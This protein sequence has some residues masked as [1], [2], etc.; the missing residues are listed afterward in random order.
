MT[1]L[2]EKQASK[3]NG[4]GYVPTPQHIVEFMVGL[5]RREVRSVLEPASSD[6][7]PFLRLLLQNSPSVQVLAL[8]IDRV[9]D[10]LP[11]IQTDFLLWDTDRK[12]D[13]VIGNPPYG[14]V[15]DSSHYPIGELKERKARYRQVISTWH[16]KYNLYAAFVEKGLSLLADEGELIYI[17]P[18]SWML[19][20]DFSKLRKLL[21]LYHVDVY[22]S[23]QVFPGRNV[24]AVVLHVKRTGRNRLVL[25][26]DDERFEYQPYHGEPIRFLHPHHLQFERSGV[27]LGHLFDIRFAARS[28]EFRDHVSS[29]PL[30]GYLPVLTGRNLKPG[31]IDYETCYS[32][33]W[34]SRE[35]AYRIRPFYKQTRLVVA[36]T[37]GTRCVAAVDDRG[38]P[39]REEFQLIP[40]CEMDLHAICDYLN[41]DEVNRYL[42]EVYRNIIPHLTLWMLARI[43]VPSSLVSDRLTVL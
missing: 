20:D 4:I 24:D 22:H 17:I 38:Y 37:K 29:V 21:S 30:D 41:G 33:W 3:S 15:G 18:S 43:P 8:D 32:G 27:P 42:S 7:A 23:G 26:A 5:C 10:D 13:L 34:M 16:G 12:F 14:I 11:S 40:R 31:W 19:L 6:T 28:T 25:Y 35:W 9:P 36:H 2:V 1:G 39:W